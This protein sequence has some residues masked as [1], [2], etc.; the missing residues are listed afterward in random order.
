MLLDI[1]RSL[2]GQLRIR[3]F[4]Q[5]PVAGVPDGMTLVFLNGY[6]NQIKADFDTF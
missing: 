6:F 4:G 2:H 1:Q 5:H 3:E